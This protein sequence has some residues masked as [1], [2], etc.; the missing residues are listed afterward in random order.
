DAA[1]AGER[2]VD[3]EAAGVAE[4]VDDV[5]AGGERADGAAVVALIEEEAGLLT[6]QDV[7][8]EADAVLADRHRRRRRGAVEQ[9]ALAA[10]RALEDVGDAEG[11]SFVDEE[12]DERVA[13][14]ADGVAVE[15]QDGDGAV[16]VDDDAGK[17]VALAVEPAEGVGG[18][19]D[20]DAAA[21][22]EGGA[23]A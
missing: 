20:D 5:D 3:G 14:D 8:G 7:D 10:A 12:R 17:E 15:A 4:E 1:G 19:G 2:R 11:A 13:P 16:D 9:L 22:V 18:G 23:D 6:V 21:G